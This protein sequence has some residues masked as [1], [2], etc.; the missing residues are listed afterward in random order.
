MQEVKL[1][2]NFNWT[3]K[4]TKSTMLREPADLTKVTRTTSHRH[5]CPH[6]EIA[7]A[8]A[9]FALEENKRKIEQVQKQREKIPVRMQEA[10]VEKIQIGQQLRQEAQKRR[11]A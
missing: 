4:E 2:Q 11:E 1:T 5:C 10:K 8:Q 7:A 9:K 6:M 3:Y